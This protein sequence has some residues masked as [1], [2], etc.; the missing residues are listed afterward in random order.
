MERRAGEKRE[1]DVHPI[2]PI[3]ISFVF[4]YIKSEDDSLG[5][6]DRVPKKRKSAKKAAL[7]N[8]R[9]DSYDPKTP[10][11]QLRA[12]GEVKSIPVT[13]SLLKKVN[14]KV[15]L[16]K[17]KPQIKKKQKKKKKAKK[18]SQPKLSDFWGIVKKKKA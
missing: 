18:K 1:A 2:F 3:S 10:L 6:I 12:F 17:P 16:S 11:G 5:L 9:I 7:G 14:E 4:P 15:K 8:E 13:K